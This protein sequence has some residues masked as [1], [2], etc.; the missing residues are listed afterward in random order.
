MKREK[1]L[2]SEAAIKRAIK[3]WPLVTAW[4]S[5]APSNPLPILQHICRRMESD[6]T[7]YEAMNPPNGWG[8]YKSWLE[9]LTEWRDLC[10]AHPLTTVGVS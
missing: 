5:G 4:T 10:E 2:R 9:F 3:Q 8:D 1:D 6:P 7:T